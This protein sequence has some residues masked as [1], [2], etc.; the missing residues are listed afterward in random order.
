MDRSGREL[1]FNPAS[2][3]SPSPITVDGYG[4]L[5]F[6]GLKGVACPSVSQCTAVDNRGQQVTFNPAAP[7]SPMPTTIDVSSCPFVLFG[8]ACP[9]VSQCTAGRLQRQRGD[10]QPDLAGQPRRR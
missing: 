1:S 2:P 10:V 7:G 8:V 6:Q 4:A 9:S 5:V 3:G